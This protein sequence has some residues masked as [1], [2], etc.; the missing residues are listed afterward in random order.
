MKRSGLTWLLV[1]GLTALC[2]AAV[3]ARAQMRDLGTLPGGY[4]SIAKGIN[5]HGLIVGDSTTADWQTRAFLYT[6]PQAKAPALLL[7]LSECLRPF[8]GWG[9]PPYLALPPVAGL[10]ATKRGFNKG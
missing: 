3:P 6:P 10:G 8:V 9:H 1:C 2:L 5:N 4:Y 7:L